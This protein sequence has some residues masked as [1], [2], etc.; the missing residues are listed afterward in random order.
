MRLQFGAEVDARPQRVDSA[1]APPSPGGTTDLQHRKDR[2][3]APEHSA[4]MELRRCAAPMVEGSCGES[5]PQ[6]RFPVVRQ[7][8]DRLAGGATTGAG[9]SR[10]SKA[11]Q[12]CRCNGVAGLVGARSNCVRS[13]GR[14][15]SRTMTKSIHGE[16]VGAARS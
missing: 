4:R 15:L 11:H 14:T 8:F 7:L 6:A 5:A 1:T 10:P 2:T 13:S 9:S 16:S 12:G 3:R